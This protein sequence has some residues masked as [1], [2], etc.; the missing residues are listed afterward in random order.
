M[1]DLPHF[2]KYQFT[3][4]QRAT[5][6]TAKKNKCPGIN[7]NPLTKN[8]PHHMETSQYICNTNQLTGFYMMGAHWLLMSKS[9]SGQCLYFFTVPRQILGRSQWGQPNQPDVNHCF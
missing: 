1:Q 7:L 3:E 8:I 6:E 2:S 9:I 4:H 5:T